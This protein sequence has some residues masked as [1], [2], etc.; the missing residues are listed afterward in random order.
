[1]VVL[2][3]ASVVHFA[4]HRTARLSF[5]GHFFVDCF[6]CVVVEREELF[7]RDELTTSSTI[8]VIVLT[9]YLIHLC[10]W[11][12]GDRL[13]FLNNTMTGNDPFL[14]FVFPASLTLI[15]KK[16]SLFIFLVPVAIDHRHACG[17]K[18]FWSLC[19]CTPNM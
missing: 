18:S 2:S 10:L 17:Y 11:S 14:V 16:P 7:V 13:K 4:A 15:C 5:W 6:F 3:R 1:M 8:L 9:F 12:R 19:K